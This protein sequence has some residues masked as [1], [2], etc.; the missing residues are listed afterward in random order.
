MFLNHS[1]NVECK[2]GGNP[3]LAVCPV[4]FVPGDL[5]Q[6]PKIE[7]CVRRWLSEYHH[8][9]VPVQRSRRRFL[10]LATLTGMH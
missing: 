10:W 3:I 9:E 1:R 7:A 4:S 8:S 2:P 6:L 5:T